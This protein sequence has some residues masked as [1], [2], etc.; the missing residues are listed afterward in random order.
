LAIA[1]IPRLR[2]ARD[3]AGDED[4]AGTRI[5]PAQ[6]NSWHLRELNIERAS[7]GL[8]LPGLDRIVVIH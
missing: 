3:R 7:V 2:R 8:D 5:I 1:I 6:G 4:R